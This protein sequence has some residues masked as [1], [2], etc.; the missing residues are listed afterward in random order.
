MSLGPAASQTSFSYSQRT[1]SA[2]AYIGLEIT[3]VTFVAAA[4]RI[5]P[6]VIFL[7]WLVTPDDLADCW[8]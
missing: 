5:S 3:Q 1:A 2:P 4:E 6:S 7:G 8:S